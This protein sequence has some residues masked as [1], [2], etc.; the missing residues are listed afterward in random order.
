MVGDL[1]VWLLRRQGRVSYATHFDKA[2]LVADS[3]LELAE[4][5]RL[6]GA[7]DDIRWSVQDGI[8]KKV[9]DWDMRGLSE[10]VRAHNYRSRLDMPYVTKRDWPKNNITK[11]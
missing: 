6:A 1:T 11:T 2:K 10:M 5:L 4:R 7:P 9:L 8:T 3:L